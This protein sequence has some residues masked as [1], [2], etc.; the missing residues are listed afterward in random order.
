MS[1]IEKSTLTEDY[2]TE[3]SL[4]FFK[5]KYVALEEENTALEQENTSLKKEKEALEAKVKFYEEQIR[6]S[7]A[8]KYG[9]SSEK[10]DADQISFF[11]EAE[12]L[13]AQKSEEP[14][15]ETILYNRK[16]GKSKS[17]KTYDD[18]PVEKIYYTLPEDEQ[19]CPNCNGHLHEMK[20]E[21]RKELKIIPAQVIVV[22]HEK[23][24]YACRTCDVEEGLGTIITAP[25]KKPVLPGSMVSPSM[26]GFIM[27]KK[28]NQAMP[29]YRQEKEFINF[30]ID[31]SRQNMANWIIKGSEK[32]LKPLYDRLHE[33]LLEE[34]IIHSD[35]LCSAEHNSSYAE[36]YIM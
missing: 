17:K 7:Q 9:A 10:S 28:Y 23:Q 16:K 26:L 8:Q 35:E 12:K 13:S 36:S 3:N 20:V 15:T 4:K 30:G 1:N 18:L 22:H 19:I 33:K 6:L 31:I 14:E 27:D 24:V 32:W 2:T 34:R 25:S 29:L 11:N 21:V 5:D